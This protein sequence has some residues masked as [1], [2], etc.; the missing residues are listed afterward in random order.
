MDRET[1]GTRGQPVTVE[2]MD[3]P[4]DGLFGDTAELRVLQEIVADPYS[5]YTPGDLMQLT[6][7]S[8]PSVRRGIRVLVRHGLVEDV[9][10]ARRRPIYRTRNGSRKLVALTFVAYAVLDDRTGADSMDDAVRHYCD[11]VSPDSGAVTIADGATFVEYGDSQGV[12]VTDTVH[13]TTMTRQ[14]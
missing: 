3:M 12:F 9:S 13:E 7:L 5:D 8:G 4:F 1:H 11:C 6:G 10:R 14:V 2:G